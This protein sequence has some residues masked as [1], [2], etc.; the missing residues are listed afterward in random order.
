MKIINDVGIVKNY[1]LPRC[2]ESVCVGPL[3]DIYCNGK[4][5]YITWLFGL[6]STCPGEML[7]RSPKEVLG[8]FYRFLLFLI[9]NEILQKKFSSYRFRSFQIYTKIVRCFIAINFE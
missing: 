1:S 4:L 2:S 9:L 8:D 3:S 7:L 6:Q 5:I